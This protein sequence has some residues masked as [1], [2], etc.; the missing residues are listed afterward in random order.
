[1]FKY[2]CHKA[3]IDYDAI[4]LIYPGGAA[5]IDRAFRNGTGQYVQQQ[6]PF[7]NSWR[8]M[9]SDTWSPNPAR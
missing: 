7:P 2:A 9:G 3:S 8:R 5:D 1:M 4:N 6:G